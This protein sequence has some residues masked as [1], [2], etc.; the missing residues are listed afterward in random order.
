MDSTQAILLTAAGIALLH[1]SLGPDH[2]LP[3]AALAKAHN[4]SVRR[5][6]WV[7]AGC[8]IGHVSASLLLGLLAA[9]AG[10]SLSHV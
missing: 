2:Y 8:G 3:F 4:W 9:M 10:W 1:T 5:T 6:L 7:T